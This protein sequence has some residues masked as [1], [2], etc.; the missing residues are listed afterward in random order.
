MPLPTAVAQVATDQV[1]PGMRQATTLR[2]D[3]SPVAFD[4][5][6]L[7]GGLRVAQETAHMRLLSLG[8]IS[9]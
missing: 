8:E 5:T 6:T 2:T 3:T 9:S 4:V 7:L 1:I